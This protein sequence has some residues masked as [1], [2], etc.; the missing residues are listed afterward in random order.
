[1]EKQGRSVQ[2]SK[3]LKKQPCSR[4]KNTLT[5]TVRR[6]LKI[7]GAREVLL[8]Q[9]NLK[10]WCHEFENSYNGIQVIDLKNLGL[11]EHIFIPF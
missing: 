1:M 11:P 6:F 7:H 4:R 10:G 5:K 3:C 2:G 8:E 9:S